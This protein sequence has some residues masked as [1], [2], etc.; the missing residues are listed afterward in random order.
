MSENPYAVYVVVD[1]YFGERL[2]S[3]PI[4]AP[5][6]I[7]SSPVNRPVAERLWKERPAPTHLAGITTYGYS[8]DASSEENLLNELSTI[9]LHH[10]PYSANPPYSTIEVFGTPL[11]DKISVALTDYGFNQFSSTTDGFVATRKTSHSQT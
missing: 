3:L 5:V 9:D 8:A 7:V 11:S 6:W 10:G 2:S 4:G 1:P